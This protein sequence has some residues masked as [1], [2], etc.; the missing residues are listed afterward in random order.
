MMR[1]F[2]IPGRR[3]GLGQ[4]KSP[5]T[6]LWNLVFST[7]VKKFDKNNGPDIKEGTLLNKRREKLEMIGNGIRNKFRND[8]S[9]FWKT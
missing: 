5:G 6:S 2:S 4:S 1:M 7:I 9:E 8:W 3:K